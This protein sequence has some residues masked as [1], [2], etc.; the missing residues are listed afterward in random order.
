MAEIF[1][2]FGVKSLFDEGKF[3]HDIYGNPNNP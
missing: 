2:N 1:V 3:V